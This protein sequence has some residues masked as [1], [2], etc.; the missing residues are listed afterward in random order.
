MAICFNPT[1]Y[2]EL[3]IILMSLSNITPLA[4]FNKLRLGLSSYT[5]G[6]NLMVNIFYKPFNWFNF[7]LLI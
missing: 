2:H 7:A 4:N 5:T 3:I 1:Y 6:H